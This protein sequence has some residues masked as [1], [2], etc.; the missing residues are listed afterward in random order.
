VTWV[1]SF[2]ALAD[3]LDTPGVVSEFDQTL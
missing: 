3:L 2:T 1:E